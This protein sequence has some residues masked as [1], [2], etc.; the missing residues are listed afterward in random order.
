MPRP[1]FLPLALAAASA[2][3]T[4]IACNR[5]AAPGTT[6]DLR[7][8]EP[9]ATERTAP[10][11]PATPAVTAG[12]D[13]GIV[14]D[15][16]A[17]VAVRCPSWLASGPWLGLRHADAREAWWAVDG[18]PVCAVPSPGADD[19][20]QFLELPS[21]ALHTLDRDD[22][23]VPD[24][25]DLLLGAKQA[26]ATSRSASPE[27]LAP[28]AAPPPNTAL[29]TAVVTS[30]LRNA[31]YD[32][33][34]PLLP[35]LRAH[36]PELP[37][38]P[39]DTAFPY[40]PG[41]VCVL[42]GEDGSTPASIG[43]VSD[44]VGPSGLPLLVTAGIDSVEE[45]DLLG[46]WRVLHRFRVA[47]PVAPVAPRDA[48]LSGLLRRRGFTV[49][50]EARQMLLVTAPLWI[51]SGGQLRRYQRSTAT[52]PWQPVGAPVSVRLGSAG[53]G[54]GR[55]L[56][57]P[58]ACADAPEKREGDKRAPA[59]VF[60]LGTAFGRAARAPFAPSRWPYRRTTPADRF[61]DD[62]RSPHYNT[63][64]VAHGPVSWSSAE[65]L[66]IYS[67]GL[68]VEHNTV[69]TVPGAGSA[70]FLHPWQA[71]SRPTVGC[72]ALDE[73]ALVDVL[74]W[75]DPDARPVL[76]QVAGTLLAGS[77]GPSGE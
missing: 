65:R 17:S 15:R 42:A 51:S 10:S 54:R 2:P 71:P 6:T 18:I 19:R 66:T 14:D 56:H 36:F 7:S 11:A 57:G 23:G 25:V 26:A 22:D 52:S 77:G 45:Q 43:V 53:L 39:T 72:T 21:D 13:Q 40:L 68:V 64:Q 34:G 24:A 8:L 67:L 58:E 20:S 30:A 41:D 61:V 74:R 33:I 73:A 31:G 9:K 46:Q 3:L 4:G 59:G 27:Q 12:I 48:G 35:Y 63:W 38:D 16:N 69:D 75:L 32:P 37:T 5:S 60:A 76:V 62:P 47:R 55:G 44:R 1:A 49:P 50:R 29:R 70:I 28:S